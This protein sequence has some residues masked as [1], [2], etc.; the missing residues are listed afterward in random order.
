[1]RYDKLLEPL[2][3]EE[4][5][6]PDLDEEGDGEEGDSDDVDE[7]VIDNLLTYLGDE[8]RPVEVELPTKPGADPALGHTQ[9]L[10]SQCGHRDDRNHHR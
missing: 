10:S 3:D 5:C 2:S 4:P 8:V 1:M 7:L 6:G 9:G